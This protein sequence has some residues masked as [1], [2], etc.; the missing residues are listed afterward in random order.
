[1]QFLLGYRR[2][3]R[4]FRYSKRSAAVKVAEFEKQRA[5]KRSATSLSTPERG[6]GCGPRYAW[7]SSATAR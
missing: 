7:S 5:T 4:Q 1:L 6:T 3:V 2:D